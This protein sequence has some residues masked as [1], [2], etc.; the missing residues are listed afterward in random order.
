MYLIWTPAAVRRAHG[1]L[2]VLCVCCV[3]RYPYYVECPSLEGFD[4][5][6]NKGQR[7]RVTQQTPPPPS[8]IKKMRQKLYI[9]CCH[10]V[11]IPS[12]L[13]IPLL[14]YSV[15]KNTCISFSGI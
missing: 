14:L 1:D 8:E 9:L 4:E 6:Q 12:H 7:H 10:S 15:F 11:L 3:T 5:V 2:S 13:Y